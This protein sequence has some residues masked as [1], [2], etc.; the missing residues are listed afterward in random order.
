MIRLVILGFVCICLA[1][2]LQAGENPLLGPWQTPFGAPPWPDIQPDHFLPAFEAAI[3]A[4][5]L[6]IERIS[7]NPDPATFANTLEALDASGELLARVGGVFSTL[8]SA[9]TS[10]R[11]QELAQQVAPR[12]TAHADALALNPALFVRVK[13]VY[14]QREAL[15][16]S[17]EQQTL[18]RN[19]YRSFVRGGALLNG[20]GQEELRKINEELSLLS[21]RFGDNLLQVTNEYRLVLDKPEDLRGLPQGVV[22]A[23]AEAAAKAGLPG[24]WVFTLQAPSVMPFLTY[25]DVRPLREQLYRAFTTR[26]DLGGERDN[27]AI[28]VRI[29]GLRARKAQL[30]GF[31]TWADFTLDERMAKTPARVI[32]LLDQLWV[33]GL[34]KA[35]ADAADLQADIDA[36]GG[37]FKLAAWDW[38]Y[39]AEKRRKTLYDLDDQTLRPYFALD[40]VRQGVFYVAGRLYGLTFTERT[41]V[42]V[43]HPEV[44]A[45]EVKEKDGRSIGLLYVDYHPRPG[46]RSGAWCD[47]LRD[48]WVKDG[49]NVPPIVINVGNFARPVDGQPAL[50][51]LGEVETLFHEFG[52]ALHILLSNCHYRSLGGANV[53]WDFVELPS[54]IMEHWV[55]EPEVLK[56]YARHYQTGEVIPAELIEKVRKA[57]TFNQSYELV[58]LV[59]SSRLDMDWHTLA[60]VDGVEADAF[61]K[62]SLGRLGLIPE[63]PPM[64]R[65]PYFRHIF[66]GGY[67]AGYYSYL[68]SAVLDC[69][70]F[71]A[72]KE[73]G[74]IFDPKT[75]RAFREQILSRGGT[76]EALTLYLRFRGAEPKVDALLRNRGLN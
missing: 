51:G 22:S 3:A 27:K 65:T 63:I 43:Y 45:F 13:A 60:T 19:T 35:K 5:R 24:K 10:P 76:E 48:Q 23:A 33:P 26:C 73:A 55:K 37:G 11:L 64:H 71:Q 31:A 69:D 8:T 72:F 41:D 15:S 40:N 34:A 25:S 38:R 17:P 61:E 74:D 28:L 36:A 59:A 30:L 4:H 32:A 53:A 70:A 39:Y 1:A 42:P 44:K 14:D 68:W 62:A 57:E 2:V 16:L 75:A 67:A 18:L 56:V 54:Q 21:L 52:H 20:A 6:E 66:S 46:K 49:Q 29:A 47:A 50:L 7:K 58:Q 12:L 9:E